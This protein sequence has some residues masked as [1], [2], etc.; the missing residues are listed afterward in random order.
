MAKWLIKLEAHLKTVSPHQQQQFERARRTPFQK[1]N[2]NNNNTR[3]TTIDSPYLVRAK[4]VTLPLN[5]NLEDLFIYQTDTEGNWHLRHVK[6]SQNHCYTGHR[7]DYVPRVLLQYISDHQNA[8]AYS[9][10]DM[11]P[12]D[13]ALPETQLSHFIKEGMKNPFDKYNPNPYPIHPNTGSR[14]RPLGRGRPDLL[15]RQPPTYWRPMG[16][17]ESLC[18]NLNCPMEKAI[19]TMWLNPS[20]T[21]YINALKKAQETLL[22]KPELKELIGN[23]KSLFSESSSRHDLGTAIL[24]CRVAEPENI[25]EISKHNN[26]NYTSVPPGYIP[27]KYVD[28]DMKSTGNPIRNQIRHIGREITQKMD[29]L[30]RF[31]PC[32]P[33][34]HVGDCRFQPQTQIQQKGPNP[35]QM[36]S[37]GRANIKCFNCANPPTLQLASCSPCYMK[38]HLGSTQIQKPYQKGMCLS[39][40]GIQTPPGV[41]QQRC[42]YCPI[43]AMETEARR[44]MAIIPNQKPKHT[45]QQLMKQMKPVTTP[46]LNPAADPFNPATVQA[47]IA[48]QMRAHNY[49]QVDG[50]ADEDPE[51]ASEDEKDFLQMYQQEKDNDTQDEEEDEEENSDEIRDQGYSMTTEYT[52]FDRFGV[53]VEHQ[54]DDMSVRVENME[55]AKPRI[56]LSPTLIAGVNSNLKEIKLVVQE[57]WKLNTPIQKQKEEIEEILKEK[58]DF[59]KHERYPCKECTFFHIWKDMEHMQDDLKMYQIQA[60]KQCIIRVKCEYNCF[61]VI[62]YEQGKMADSPESPDEMSEEEAY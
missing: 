56:Q 28:I 1:R 12:I 52:T 42:P 40:R 57:N 47:S 45:L 48:C 2:T 17:R 62:N 30:Y 6:Y 22:Y 7:D 33:K 26:T 18:I 5:N 55:E 34:C 15:P 4:E 51:P 53:F 27:I 23:I 43:T 44:K 29:R 38:A 11:G 14:G 19:Y 58:C 61:L 59:H 60:C 9:N 31:P 16:A 32:N 13:G 24:A 8:A 37:I 41:L 54:D 20:S 21:N 25:R 49:I 35:A 39:C 36:P 50:T 3:T 10:K 46:S